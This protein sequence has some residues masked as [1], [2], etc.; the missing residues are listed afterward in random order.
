MGFALKRPEF[1]QR[2]P[3]PQGG[4]SERSPD[5]CAR[6]G[7][8]G[9]P[10]G[11]PRSACWSPVTE[12]PRS[13]QNAPQWLRN[14]PKSG[15]NSQLRCIPQPPSRTCQVRHICRREGPQRDAP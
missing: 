8:A 7:R 9:V 2:G 4:E 1:P 3:F 12:E 6:C 10:M 13:A 11:H 15:K 5:A 14:S